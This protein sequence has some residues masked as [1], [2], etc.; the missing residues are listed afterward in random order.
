MKLNEYSFYFS[1]NIPSNQYCIT[2]IVGS[3]TTPTCPGTTTTAYTSEMSTYIEIM[4][5][6]TFFSRIERIFGH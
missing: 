4:L 1:T 3:T 2:F 5:V 6:K